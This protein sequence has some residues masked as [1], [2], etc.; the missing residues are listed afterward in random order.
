MPLKMV[1]GLLGIGNEQ[2]VDLPFTAYP[3]VLLEYLPG[4]HFIL[5]KKVCQLELNYTDLSNQEK[6]PEW[7]KKES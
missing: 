7:S 1:P 2:V 3:F 5:Q 6:E 4:A